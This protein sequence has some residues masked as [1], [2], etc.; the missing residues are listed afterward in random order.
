MTIKLYKTVDGILRYHEAWVSEDDEVTEHWGVV[1]EHGESREHKTL[2][3]ESEDDA[4][5][6]V[7][8]EAIENGYGPIDME[9]HATLL[10]EYA[11]SGMGTA[12][13]LDKR[14]ALEDHLNEA[15]GWTGLGMCDGGSIGSGTMEV[16]CFVVDFA[17]AKRVIEADLA[18][19]GFSDFTRIYREEEA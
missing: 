17:I 3:G 8:R 6:R 12:D 13:D 18:E 10:V 4:V 14:H 9:D 2:A 11:I 19:T 15:L 5:I 16:C 7:L 1:G